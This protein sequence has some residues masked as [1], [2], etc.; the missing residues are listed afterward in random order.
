MH[1]RVVVAADGLRSRL[2]HAAGLQKQ[3]RR[4]RYGV[5]AHY[6]M[7]SAPGDGVEVYF[8]PSYEVYVTPVGGSL[9]NVAVLLDAATARRLGGRLEGAFD[10]LAVEG[11]PRLRE[12]KRA[13]AALAAGPFP[14]A[15]TRHWAGNLVLAGDAGG[16]F[17]GITGEGMSLALVGAKHCASAVEAFLADGDGAH[18]A[19]YDRAITV[20]QRPSTLMARLSLALAARPALGRRAIANLARRPQTLAN[21]VRVSQGEAALTSLRPRDALALLFG[22]LLRR[23]MRRCLS[24]KCSR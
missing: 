21:L 11:A 17:D 5:S 24:P 15:A 23:G 6:E 19:R 8:R 7:P 10:A 12:G 18:F 20:L 2:R 14:A 9:V 1:T 4:R 16:F 22:V 13:D 3:L